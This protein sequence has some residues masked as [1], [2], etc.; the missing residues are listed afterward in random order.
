[1][2]THSPNHTDLV[3]RRSLIVPIS[4]FPAERAAADLLPLKLAPSGKFLA[5]LAAA[6]PLHLQLARQHYFADCFQFVILSPSRS[7]I[8]PPT[9]YTLNFFESLDKWILP[10]SQIHSDGWKAYDTLSKEGYEH[11]K[12]NHSNTFV[13]PDN[14]A[15]TN[16][17]EASWRAAKATTLLTHDQQDPS[18]QLPYYDDFK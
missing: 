11:S 3:R 6:D 15:F 12:V 14:G 1:M 9:K 8:D 16:R 17:I 13:N 4:D 18:I 10:G 5:E 2:N 7:A